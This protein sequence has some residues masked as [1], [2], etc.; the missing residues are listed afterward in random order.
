MNRT[1]L[2]LPAAALTLGLMLSLPAAAGDPPDNTAS[3]DSR[4]QGLVASHSRAMLDRGGWNNPWVRGDRYA[5]GAPLLTVDAGSG[6]T[7]GGEPQRAV[8]RLLVS[9]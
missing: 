7:T 5:A 3:A 6:V 9:R 1:I 2:P 8:A 4:L